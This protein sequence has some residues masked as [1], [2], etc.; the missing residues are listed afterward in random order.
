LEGFG[1]EKIIIFSCKYFNPSRSWRLISE[2]VFH[3][4]FD[5]FL[6]ESQHRN[7][8]GS[9]DYFYTKNSQKYWL[10]F[11]DRVAS[12]YLLHVERILD[13]LHQYRC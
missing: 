2:F 7:F 3:C 8:H 13:F 1:L 4:I 9:A 6:E 11:D 10:Y 12:E 5:S